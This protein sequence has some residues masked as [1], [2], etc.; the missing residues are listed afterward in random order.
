MRVF[1][2]YIRSIACLNICRIWFET[3]VTCKD[4]A[5]FRLSESKR[6]KFILPS[7]RNLSKPNTIH[8]E[9]LDKGRL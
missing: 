5:K 7:M 4:N 6:N 2:R 9:S 3:L 8:L 1:Y